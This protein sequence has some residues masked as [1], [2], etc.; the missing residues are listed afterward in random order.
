MEKGS[1]KKYRKLLCC[2]KRRN[3]IINVTAGRRQR[4]TRN[5]FDEGKVDE[6]RPKRENISFFFVSFNEFCTAHGHLF[7][8]KHTRASHRTIFHL[9]EHKNRANFLFGEDFCFS[10]FCFLYFRVS[11]TR[12]MKR[13][14]NKSIEK[15]SDVKWIAYIKTLKLLKV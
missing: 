5:Q 2:R 11:M 14:K 8:M 7:Q 9:M 6:W 10:V 3:D 4:Q 1:T 12:R 15:S 13:N